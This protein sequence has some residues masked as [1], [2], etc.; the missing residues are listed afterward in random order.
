MGESQELYAT[1][2]YIKHKVD[3]I[4]KI[5]LLNLRSNEALCAKYTTMLKSDEWLF[6]VYKAIDGVQGQKD[7]A[8]EL[9]TNEMMVS[10][11]ITKLQDAGLIEIKGVVSGKNVF[12]HSIAE[13][14]FKLTRII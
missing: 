3:A 13:V 2:N 10:R 6:K 7:I 5:E 11:K 1:V 8:A 14:A 9:D 4:E 12:K